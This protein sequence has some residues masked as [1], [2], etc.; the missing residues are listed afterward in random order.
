MQIS[1]P[2]SYL[3]RLISVYRNIFFSLFQRCFQLTMSKFDFMTSTPS[4]S[5]PFASE[6]CNA[7]LW[8]KREIRLSF[9][10]P[11]S[12]RTP[13]WLINL[14]F[15]NLSQIHSHFCLKSPHP[16]DWIITITPCQF[17]LHTGAIII[18]KM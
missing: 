13:R 11:T 3:F 6:N 18:F 16:F 5:C 10:T 15:L 1:F 8:N 2:N 7:P 12:G 9:L 4:Q 17:I 14:H